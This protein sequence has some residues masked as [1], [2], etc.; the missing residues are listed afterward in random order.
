MRAVHL[1]YNSGFE[2]HHSDRLAVK[3][4]LFTGSGDYLSGPDL[5]S[6]FGETGSCEEFKE[7]VS[8]ANGMFSVIVSRENEYW[9]ATDVARL[10]PLFYSR[11]N[12]EW[13]ISDSAE[14]LA[15]NL[16][17][18]DLNPIAGM[19]FLATGFVTGYETLISQVQ[20]A[21][22]GE[23]VRLADDDPERMFYYTWLITNAREGNAADLKTE[24]SAVFERA[25]RRF[26]TS[27][28]GRTV[29]LPL[30][31]GYD[32]RLIAVM[33]KHF[34]Y[35]NVICFTYGR[36]GNSELALSEK[37]ADALGFP[38][39]CVEYTDKLIGGFT[40]SE[41][42][43]AY[44]PFSSQLVSMFYMQEYFAVKYLKENRLI[45]PDAIFVPGHSGDFLGGSQLFKHGNL[46]L[47]ESLKKVANRL[48]S[49]K[50]CY[51]K[52]VSPIKRSMLKSRIRQSLLD[53]GAT[54]QHYSYSIHEDWDFKEKLAKFNFNSVMIYSYFGYA[55]RLPYWDRELLQFF[56]DLPLEHKVHKKLYNEILTTGYF[57][58]YGLNFTSELQPTRKQFSVQRW[59]AG[60]K[61]VLP[62]FV[63]RLFINK[64]DNIFYNEITRYFIKDLRENGLRIETF[65]NS[66]NS[67][68]IQWYLAKIREKYNGSAN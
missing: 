55:C 39:I 31:G 28:E 54:H 23:I 43:L 24:G 57:G 37:V 66:Y 29:A 12:G 22:A 44:Y 27:L 13:K 6:Y 40:E 32:S 36:R 41:D 46:A 35:T 33:L 7:R 5:L 26:I 3:G 17:Q 64:H 48:F 47:D 60:V 56:R 18:P 1:A 38:W 14:F 16:E 51:R 20:Q 65:G 10:F 4:F 25:F 2:W 8:G 67:L 59:K 58:K 45:P 62:A 61:K 50:Y 19:E 11:I 15:G 30:S 63:K 34:G 21:Q 53:K 68:I 42:F 49:I 9:L 52:P